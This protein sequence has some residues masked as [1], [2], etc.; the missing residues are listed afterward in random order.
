MEVCNKCNHE[1]HYDPY[2]GAFICRK[3]GSYFYPAK[4]FDAKKA[5]RET[6]RTESNT[7]RA[8]FD[9]DNDTFNE[10]ERNLA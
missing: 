2:F 4:P 8:F 6:V 3:C 10:D 9:S 5:G 7:R 1:M